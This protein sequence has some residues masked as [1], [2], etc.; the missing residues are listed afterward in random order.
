MKPPVAP[1]RPVELVHHGVTR[2]DP[3]F[4]M[5]RRDDPA[6]VAHLE[7]E[8][9]WTDHVMAHTEELQRALFE[10]IRGR[11]REDDTSV[12][13]LLNGWWYYTRYEEGK[14]YP[15]YARRRGSQEA[16][17]EVMLDVNLLAGGHGFYQVG[18]WD[19]STGGGLL[20]FAADTV[21]RRIHT[22]HVKDLESGEIRAS[23][24]GV[25][26][27]MV[28]A[29]D[30]RTLFYARRDPGTLRADRIYR[31]VLGTDPEE[32]ELVYHEADET[33][34][35]RVSRTRSR[36]YLLI[37]SHQTVST[38][39][40]F[41]DAGRPAEPFRI[42]LP[43]RR[44]HLYYPD[45]FGAHFY[46]RTN[47]GGENFRL[48][49]MPVPSGG[50]GAGGE[51]AGARQE[52]EGAGGLPPGG[53]PSRAGLEGEG[54]L[55]EVIPHRPDVL[56]A[57]FEIFRDHLV[58]SE[59]REGLT[60]LRVRSWGGDDDHE[61]DFG[62]PAW[63]AAVG[64]NPDFDTGTLRYL[65]SSL[66]TPPSVYDYDMQARTRIL[67]KRD[68]VL[69]GFSPDD[70]RSERIHA[71]A[72]DGARV[73]VSLVYRVGT[74]RDGTAPLVLYGY[75][76]YGN[77]TDP[78]FS[79][80]RLSLLDRGFVYAIAHVRGG[81]ELG[82][83]WYEE[84]RLERKVNTFTDFIAAAETLAAECYSSPG[85]MYA[86]GGSAGGLLVG[87]VLNL[88]PDLFDGAIAAVPFVDVVTTML[89]ET[90]PLTTFE[91]DEWGDPRDPEAFRTLL[92]YS[93]YDNV[94][95]GP[96]P[97]LLVTTGF[98]DSQVQYWEPAKWVAKLRALKTDDRRLLLRTHMEAGHGGVSGRFRALR[99]TAFHYAF[100]LDLAGIHR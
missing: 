36:R 30:D 92:S 86:L 56:L 80:A 1:V 14:E 76:A 99:E 85:R 13:Y 61:L 60:R 97:H 73:P 70:Y 25:T 10:E 20:A 53:P 95:A 45:H 72:P 46:L 18:G 66:T 17:E 81:Q 43:R 34:S 11:I 94:R 23:I 47:D 51:G 90:I 12:P 37:G 55:E 88:R 21:G 83:R 35:V 50:P 89:D 68:V 27:N 41:V 71:T 31:H 87:A 4:W 100:L 39:F 49:R 84:G 59:R 28:W 42:L 75:G 38:E 3:Y 44:D 29:G 77:S 32:D 64:T 58:L 91:Y 82:R 22:L 33:F 96:Y 52:Q 2:V 9:A 67:R 74:R 48:V 40:R 8:N 98:H 26:A 24:P 19:V 15:V 16:P 57:G 5:N 62:E 69:G 93:P 65:Y 78:T 6:V 63:T 7:A 79:P 54:S